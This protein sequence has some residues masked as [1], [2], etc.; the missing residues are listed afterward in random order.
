MKTVKE[1]LVESLKRMGADG[2]C[3]EEC[4][5][6]LGYNFIPCS[7]P[8]CDCVAGVKR[9]ATKEDVEKG[10]GCRVGDWTI[11]PMIEEGRKEKEKGCSGGVGI[12]GRG[13]GRREGG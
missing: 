8:V 9:E 5:C 6:F 4:G 11:V 13:K 2:L 12:G 7:G 3:S 10:F 1:M